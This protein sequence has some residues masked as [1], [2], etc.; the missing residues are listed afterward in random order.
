MGRR[1]HF[2][3]AWFL[4]REWCRLCTAHDNPRASS[5]RSRAFGEGSAADRAHDRTTFA[6]SLPQKR[7][8]NAL[9]CSAETR[10]SLRHFHALPA[11][12]SCGP[13]N[14]AAA[15]RRLPGAYNPL[16]LPIFAS[17]FC[18]RPSGDGLFFGLSE[19]PPFNDYRLVRRRRA[20]WLIAQSSAVATSSLASA[21]AWAR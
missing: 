14:V 16:P 2:F 3:F 19:Q 7:G 6:V 10:L 1:W 12:H 8:G 9:Q 18:D 17:R 5:S 11:H 15:R 21:V 13:R 4:R 20:T